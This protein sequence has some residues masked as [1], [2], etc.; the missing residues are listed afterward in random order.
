MQGLVK[1]LFCG[2]ECRKNTGLV[3]HILSQH[4]NRYGDMVNYMTSFPGD[5]YQDAMEYLIGQDK[6]KTQPQ[7]QASNGL[8][9]CDV[10]H[11]VPKPE[12]F[13]PFATAVPVDEL[14]TLAYTN[15]KEQ[16]AQGEAKLAELE[17]LREKLTRDYDKLHQFEQIIKPVE[18]AKP[19]DHTPA[20]APEPVEV[21]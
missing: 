4:K 7:A 19:G 17:Q 12:T 6:G 8:K 16:I 2:Q 5:S 14:I 21:A 15:L 18:H 13:Q 11:G 10:S 3:K 9:S 20:L 1:C